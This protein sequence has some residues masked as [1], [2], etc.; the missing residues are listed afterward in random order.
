MTTLGS[1]ARRL[2]ITVLQQL[3]QHR[4]ELLYQ[5]TAF[6]LQK[7]Y[8]ETTLNKSI[9]NLKFARNFFHQHSQ[10]IFEQKSQQFREKYVSLSSPYVEVGIVLMTLSC[11]IMTIWTRVAD[12]VMRFESLSLQTG[13]PFTSK[14]AKAKR[15]ALRYGRGWR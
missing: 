6:D 9:E 4:T 10:R 5:L 2:Q 12:I 15:L 13:N 11:R 3:E 7:S 1:K 14:L 8:W